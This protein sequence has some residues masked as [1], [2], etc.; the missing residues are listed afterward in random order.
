ML[1]SL[2]RVVSKRFPL[3]DQMVN[4]LGFVYQLSLCC[5]FLFCLHNP[6]KMGGGIL[7]DRGFYRNRF[8]AKFS[9]QIGCCLTLACLLHFSWSPLL[10]HFT[11]GG[12]RYQLVCLRSYYSLDLKAWSSNALG[13]TGHYI[14]GSSW[15][16]PKYAI[17]LYLHLWTLK[18]INFPSSYKTK[19]T[20]K[21]PKVTDVTHLCTLLFKLIHINSIFFCLAL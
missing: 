21:F 19:P 1:T 15:G 10:F 20:Q 2:I 7:F 4:I 18:T 16:N 9:L 8:G 5:I 12:L 3:S 6:L 11:D 17:S 14:L 13:I